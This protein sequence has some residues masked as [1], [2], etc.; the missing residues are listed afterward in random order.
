LKRVVSR[1]RLGLRALFLVAMAAAWSGSAVAHEVR[2]AY[3]ELAEIAPGRFA[4]LW[5]QPLAGELR[6]R[7]EPVFPP[8]CTVRS[9]G[10]VVPTGDALLERF[11]LDCAAAGAQGLEGHTV[12]VAGLERTLTDALVRVRFADGRAF[13]HLLR[14][15]SPAWEVGG[16]GGVAVLAYLRLGIE[17]LLFGF[18]HILF[19]LGLLLL[20]RE[21]MA[22]VRVI[23]AFTVA[24]SVTLALSATGVVSLPRGPIEAVIALSVLFLAVELA[25][26]LQGRDLGIAG[27]SPWVVAF[28]FGLLHGFG[29]AGALAEI[30]LPRGSAA[31]ALLLFNLGVELGQL[32]IVAA[33]LAVASGARAVVRRRRWALPGWSTALPVLALGVLSAYWF[34]ERVAAL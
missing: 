22:L 17:H 23:T 24:H 10:A 19:V 9:L 4:V 16:P 13:T 26:Q 28:G 15:V 3:L 20:V 27:R 6:L 8:A 31:A 32:A 11:E 12:G 34:W 33:A 1:A 29:F 30:G 7:I 21:P 25:R 5:K 14:P 2:P 18:D